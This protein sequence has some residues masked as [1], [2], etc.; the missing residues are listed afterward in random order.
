MARVTGRYLLLAP[1]DLVV[2]AEGYLAELGEL[3]VQRQLVVEERGPAVA[4]EGLHDDEPA[5]PTLHIFVGLAGCA[6][7]L[8][9][10]DLEVGEVVGVVYVSL[11]VYLRVA[12]PDFRLVDYPT[13]L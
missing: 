12:D 3:R 6:Q 4:D 5:S 2:E 8:D 13:D 9:A 10:A 1:A 11:R 7:P